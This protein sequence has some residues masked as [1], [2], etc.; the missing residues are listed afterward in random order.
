MGGCRWVFCIF[1]IMSVN[2][3]ILRGIGWIYGLVDRWVM[4]GGYTIDGSVDTG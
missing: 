2:L 3:A 1:Q 4:Y